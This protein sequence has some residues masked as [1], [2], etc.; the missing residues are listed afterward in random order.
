MVERNVEVILD[1]SG[2]AVKAEVKVGMEG[3]GGS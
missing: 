2:G 1:G 3:V